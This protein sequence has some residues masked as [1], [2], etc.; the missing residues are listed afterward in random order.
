MGNGSE[1]KMDLKLMK[2][3]QFAKRAV[4]FFMC[5]FLAA[6]QSMGGVV[7]NPLVVSL[8]DAKEIRITLEK[9]EYLAPVRTV[10]DMVRIYGKGL[11]NCIEGKP[12]PTKI[13]RENWREGFDGAAPMESGRRGN[14]HSWARDRALEASYKGN[15]HDAVVLMDWANEE[16]LRSKRSKSKGSIRSNFYSNFK[17]FEAI[18]LAN[19]GDL[20]NAQIAFD[21]ANSKSA[22]MSK[23]YDQQ[24]ALAVQHRAAGIL[25]RMNGDLVEAA[26]M[27]SLSIEYSARS[28]QLRDIQLS[29]RAAHFGSMRISGL[30]YITQ[31]ELAEVVIMQGNPVEGES[32]IR[33]ALNKNPLYM[34]RTPSIITAILSK[35]PNALVAQGRLDEAQVISKLVADLYNMYCANN[36]LGAATAKAQSAKSL[37]GL[38]RYDEANL[39]FSDIKQTFSDEPKLLDLKFADNLGWAVSDVLSGNGNAASGRTTKALAIVRERLGEGSFVEAELTGV[40]AMAE[41]RGQ[42]DT[43]ARKHFREFITAYYV[44]DGSETTS[45]WWLHKLILDDYLDLLIRSGTEQD[46]AESIQITQSAQSGSV[47]RALSQNAARAGANSPELSD[48]IRRQQDITHQIDRVQQTI[49]AAMSAPDGAY[50]ESAATLRQNLPQLKGAQRALTKEITAQFPK[51]G[52]LI[53][54]KPLSV[55]QAQAV[56]AADDALLLVRTLRDKTY[57]WAVPK[58]GSVAF[59]RLDLGKAQLGTIVDELRIAVDPGAIETLADIP[60]YD[61]A[62]AHALFKQLLLP[63]ASGWKNAKTLKVVAQ[64]PLAR[65]PLSMLVTDAAT[66]K[67]G[68][69]YFSEYR[70]VKWLAQSHAVVT[71]PSISSLTAFAEAPDVT[72]TRVFVGFGD[73]Y[74]NSEQAKA[75]LENMPVEVAST[76]TRGMP[77]RLRS[78]PTTRSVD[79]ADLSLLPRLPA[80]A[81]ELMSIAKIIGADPEKDVF[82]GL[83][84]NEKTVKDMKLDDVRVLAFATH[85]LVSGDLNGLD[86]PALA[87]SAPD[88]AGVDGDGLLTMGEILTLKLNAEWVVLSACN[89]A[90]ADG[91]G[92]EAISG[93]GRAFFYA[94]ARSLLV[95]NWPVH[96]GAT[97]ELTT[98]LFR[99]QTQDAVSNR[100]WALQ[101]TRLAMIENGAQK[102]QAGD[103]LFSYAH[104]IFWAPFTIVG[105]GGG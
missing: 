12:Q 20:T 40:L 51:Y 21:I 34:W 33:E 96:S 15:F 46:I 79:S 97:A 43:S 67:P 77:L 70:N 24:Y 89:T 57:V 9:A 69:L 16:M 83:R 41:A 19:A 101:Q 93:L 71:L 59:A 28:I 45:N 52:Q 66:V 10:K 6:C 4:P 11:R 54:P 62:A 32:L 1:P 104:P 18:Y 64:G 90:S 81:T 76:A 100:A 63:V 91:Q 87:L 80:T 78:K 49:F 98:T 74:F 7:Q 38:G 37:L 50:K 85:G 39:V 3:N 105:D 47:Q 23:A 61:V 44:V 92:A 5:G 48:L 53:N 14:K 8:K 65:L 86:Q 13:R 29:G 102:N 58:S 25:A 17:Y 75:A 95:S 56:M 68:A 84:A 99:I 103:P 36:S 27:L 60:A 94:G 72:G 31:S 42:D 30:Q 22:N 82:L 88:V 55:K 26:S 2:N 35:L 73:P